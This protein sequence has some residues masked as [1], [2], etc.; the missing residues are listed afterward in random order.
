M[1]YGG[2]AARICRTPAVVVSVPGLGYLFM[3]QGLKA[4]MI[5]SVVLFLYRLAL[6]M[7][8][9]RVIFQNANDREILVRRGGVYPGEIDHDLGF[10]SRFGQVRG[11]A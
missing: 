4:F 6:G 10:R 3:A 1:L 2:L 9:L 5:R 8:N 11:N 7:D